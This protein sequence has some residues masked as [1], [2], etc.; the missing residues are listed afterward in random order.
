MQNL[1]IRSIFAL[2]AVGILFAGLR[3][4]MAGHQ[5]HARALAGLE[6][7]QRE[8]AERERE[9]DQLAI[10]WQRMDQA[11]T[12][13]STL[14][15]VPRHWTS[16][17]LVM[18]A[19]LDR[20]QAGSALRLLGRGEDWTFLRTEALTMRSECGLEPCDRFHIDLRAEVFAPIPAFSMEHG[21]H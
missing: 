4:A 20:E 10:A 9:R 19:V 13:L 2:L 18:R 16:Y 17:P 5:E 1:L 11:G 8:L 12:L 3:F 14:E 21:D 7:A 15:P 6:R